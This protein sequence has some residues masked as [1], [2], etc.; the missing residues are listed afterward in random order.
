[1]LLEKIH[2]LMAFGIDVKFGREINQFRI[3]LSKED[4]A[5]QTVVLPF[6]HLSEKRICDYIN[7]MQEKFK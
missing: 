4:K 7:L 2:D 3:T 6:N 5:D 1:M